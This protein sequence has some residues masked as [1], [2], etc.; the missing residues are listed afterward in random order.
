[1]ILKQYYL[2]CLSQASYLIGDEESG[3]AVVVDPRRDVLEY[4]EDARELGLE[5][6]SVFLTHFHAD[7]VAGHLELARLTKAM[8]HL[9][10]KAEA[11]FDFVPMSDGMSLDLGRVRLEV[12]ETPGHTPESICLLVTERG[13]GPDASSA[14]LTGDTMFIG[15]VGR[16]DLGASEDARAADYASD[17]H[18]SLQRLLALPDRTLVYPGHGAGSMCGKNL[19]RESVSTIGEQRRSNA[20]LQPMSRDEFIRLVTSDLPQT[21]DYFAYDATLNRQQRITLDESLEKALVAIP[22]ERALRVVDAG[23]VILDVREAD[24]YAR[25]HLRGSI[26]IGLS[27]TYAI[28]AG[29][30]L[31]PDRPI[32]LVS[33]PGLEREAA[34]RLGRI[35]F[36]RVAGY[37]ESGPGALGGGG[38]R[39]ESIE[40]VTVTDLMR[41]LESPDPPLLLD[42]RSPLEREE[43][44]IRGSSHLPLTRFRPGI[45]EI[46][47]GRPIVV[48]CRSGYR[49]SIAAS[50]LRC[51]GYPDATDLIGG[52]A[53]WEGRGLELDLA[54]ERQMSIPTED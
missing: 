17:L 11:D 43:M 12:M 24:A 38:D 3:G 37:V 46:P 29:T 16:P 48:Y 32:V 47:R 27:G 41:R 45:M 40:R 6:R 30:L 33:D 14:V 51:N 26:N 1:L 25:G 49:S 39:V 50:L 44:Q 2:G 4:I 21:P 42:V 34:V 23:G 10:R 54:A 8:I 18:G 5:I 28:W 22:V 7:F 31:D 53:E 13:S 15:D 9:G 35:G 20:A 19:S 36:D 52:I